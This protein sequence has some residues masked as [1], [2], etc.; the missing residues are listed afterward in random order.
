MGERGVCVLRTVQ[1]NHTPLSNLT[2]SEIRGA[3]THDRLPS[4]SY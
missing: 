2:L 1:T 3:D 4:P